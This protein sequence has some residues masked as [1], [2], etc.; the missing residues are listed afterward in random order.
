MPN[1]VSSCGASLLLALMLSACSAGPP[2][3]GYEPESALIAFDQVRQT[4]NAFK[5]FPVRWSGQIVQTRVLATGTE[6]EVVELALRGDGV[7]AQQEQSQGRFIIQVEGLLDPQL[8][9]QGRTITVLG[10]YQGMRAGK[11]GEQA[12]SFAVLKADRHRLWPK[13]R[14]VEVRY[15]RDP[16]A[17]F[18]LMIPPRQFR[19]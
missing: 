12:Y 11:I 1:R 19:P 7:P 16:F 14:D 3:L 17:D 2:G 5:G 4:P 6:I 8:Y 15:V 13:V 10:T 18:D 9:A